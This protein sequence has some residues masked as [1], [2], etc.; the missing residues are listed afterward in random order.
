MTRTSSRNSRTPPKT[1]TPL[2]AED[3]RKQH[4]ALRP[5]QP[6]GKIVKFPISPGFPLHFKG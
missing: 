3:R 6:V 1:G 5:P 2:E 4:D